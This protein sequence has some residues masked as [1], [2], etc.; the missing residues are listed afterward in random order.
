ML[1]KSQLDVQQKGNKL[2]MSE[3][4]QVLKGAYLRKILLPHLFSFGWQ[5]DST[6]S[7]LESQGFKR[8]L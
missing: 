3:M 7:R 6:P 1:K 2:H 5:E 8:L 4:L